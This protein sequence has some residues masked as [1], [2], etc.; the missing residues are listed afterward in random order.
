[1]TLIDRSYGHIVMAMALHVKQLGAINPVI[2]ISCYM[3]TTVR[4]NTLGRPMTRRERLRRAGILCCHFLRNLAFYHSWHKAGTPFKKEQ[5]WVNANGN[6]IDI[7]VLEWCKLFADKKGK[8][9]FSKVVD[10]YKRFE[11]DLLVKLGLD[12]DGFEAYINEFRTY[13]DK[14][15]AH[16]DDRNTMDIPNMKIAKRCAKYLYQWLLAQEDKTDTFIDAPKSSEKLYQNFLK[17]G[18]KV[19]RR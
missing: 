14:F 4:I 13:R 15:I 16:L 6:F 5:F 9:Y 18:M 19:Y 3:D 12:N 10:E 8:H 2:N 17:E 7:A 11:A 1:M